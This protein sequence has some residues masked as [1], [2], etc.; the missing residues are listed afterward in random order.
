M[1]LVEKL[2][3]SYPLR[4]PWLPYLELVLLVQIL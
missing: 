2:V 1:K 4:S 3:V